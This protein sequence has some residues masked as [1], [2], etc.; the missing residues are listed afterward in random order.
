MGCG[1]LA[2]YPVLSILGFAAIGIGLGMGLSFWE[3]SDPDTKDTALD[4]IGLVGDLFIRALK[5]V[6]LP[7]VFVNVT[8]A[9]VEMMAVGRAGSVGGKTIGFYLLTTLIASIL[10]LVSILCFK[11]T[12]QEESFEASS[13]NTIQLG[14]SD[15]EGSFLAHM[16]DGSVTC[17]ADLTND[18]MTKFIIHDLDSTFVKA[19]SGPQDNISMSDTIRQGVFEKLIPSNI[20]DAFVSSNFAGVVMFAIA[21]GVALGSIVLKKAQQGGSVVLVFLKELDEILMTI[22]NW[23]ILV[24]P[25]AVM[26]L[27]ANAI[28]KQDDLKTAFTNVGYLVAA[29]VCAM[30]AHFI[31]VYVGLYLTMIKSNPWSYFKHLILAQTTAFACASSAATLPVTLQAVRNTG[32][33]PDSAA[34]FVA[35]LG[36]TINM[37]GSAIYFPCACIWMAV[38]NGIEPS[39]ADCILLD[40]LAT[41]G[42]AGAAPVPS[43]G[44]VLIITAYNTTF[45]TTGTPEGFSYILAIDWFMDRLRTSLNVTGDAVVCGLVAHTSGLSGAANDA[46]FGEPTNS[47]EDGSSWLLWTTVLEVGHK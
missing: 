43:A 45:G 22:I 47:V 18:T 44:L 12:F 19:S 11:G 36:A 35:S 20:F 29:T 9:V 7:L 16:S 2:R 28:G 4:W 34:R 17:T 39:V 32:K 40:V 21:V 6:I 13:Q 30:A 42:S 10:G 8:L 25:F 33:V 37:D 24:T 23:C 41:V 27:I 1:I 26:S 31:L 15:E 46:A 3:P 38:L 14:C 5:A